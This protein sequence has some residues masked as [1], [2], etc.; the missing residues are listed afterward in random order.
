MALQLRFR[1]ASAIAGLA[2]CLLPGATAQIQPSSATGLGESS[3]PPATSTPSALDTGTAP[4]APA[5]DP[6][7]LFAPSLPDGANDPLAPAG[8]GSS[9]GPETLPP[10]QGSADRSR[11]Q[12]VQPGARPSAFGSVKDFAS[13]LGIRQLI[14]PNSP[15]FQPL[16]VSDFRLVIPQS[17]GRRGPRDFRLSIGT[18][19][20][21]PGLG[22]HREGFSAALTTS[23]L[24]SA[25]ALGQS[26]P[27]KADARMAWPAIQSLCPDAASTPGS[28][29]DAACPG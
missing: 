7:G 9:T 22:R 19:G 17:D 2:L 25:P 24:S 6:L 21:G 10:V 13:E 16:S 20:P 8:A 29:S 28:S 1:L 14:D 12:V 4:E 18:A 27:R 15:T 23:L 5:A 3:T 11:P 26:G